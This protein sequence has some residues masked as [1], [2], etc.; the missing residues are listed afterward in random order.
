MSRRRSSWE[1]VRAASRMAMSLF[2]ATWGILAHRSTSSQAIRDGWRHLSD[3]GAQQ[4]CAPTEHE[5]GSVVVFVV[6]DHEEVAVV[7]RQDPAVLGDGE[8]RVGGAEGEVEEKV[9]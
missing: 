2:M 8:R 7:L 5:D 4:G 1:S 3:R 9:V 6:A